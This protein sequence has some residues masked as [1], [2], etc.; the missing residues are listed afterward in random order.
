MSFDPCR[1]FSRRQ[2]RAAGLSDSVLA[3]ERFTT[4]FRGVHVSSAVVLTDAVRAEAA[5]VPFAASTFASHA[6]AARLHR[7]PIPPIPDEHVTVLDRAARRSRTGIRCHLGADDHVVS[8]GGVRVSD[9]A[10]TFVELGELVGLVDLVI[11]GDHLVASGRCTL[12]A[13][14]ARAAAARG[15]GARAARAA[16][17]L[18]RERVDSPMETRLRLLLVL[19]GLPEP[20]VNPTIRDDR[21]EPLRRYDLYFRSSGTAVEYDGRHHIA[22]EEQWSADLRRREAIDGDGVRLI[23]VVATDIFRTPDDLLRRVHR[24]LIERRE[25]GVPRRLAEGW[26]PHFPLRGRAA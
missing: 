19:A 26:R 9:P 4:V 3:G 21:G 23:V 20:E 18:V 5:L 16:A 2:A 25:P 24:V 1:P 6:S 8:V 13:L 11:A 12:A 10:R 15:P 22:R 7:I 14:R 17:R